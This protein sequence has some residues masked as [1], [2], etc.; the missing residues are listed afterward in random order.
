LIIQQQLS[1]FTVS[2]DP[3]QARIDAA[4]FSSLHSFCDAGKRW[5]NSEIKGLTDPELKKVIAIEFGIFGGG[6]HPETHC[7]QGGAD[8]KFWLSSITPHGRPTLRG[9]PLLDRVRGLLMIPYPLT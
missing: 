8:P 7:H 4:L 6:S 9:Q 3:Y 2:I 1:L 5:R